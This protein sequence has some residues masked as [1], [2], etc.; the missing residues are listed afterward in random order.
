[1]PIRSFSVFD[2]SFSFYF[3]LIGL[4]DY[5][6]VMK[7]KVGDR[8]PNFTNEEKEMMKGRTIATHSPLL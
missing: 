4:G 2:C 3:V 6:E 5:P 8:L 1:M 7:Q